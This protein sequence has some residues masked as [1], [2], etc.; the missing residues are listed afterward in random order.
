MS[1]PPPTVESWLS[2]EQ[3]RSL[4]NDVLDGLTKPF[5][6]LSPKHLYDARGSE[7][8]E[9]I[10][11]LP[12]YYPTRTEL[13]ILRDRAT[14]VV[15]DT[16]AAELVELGAGAADKARLLLDAM[17]EAGTLRRYVP[18]DVS[19]SVVA[20]AATTLADAY[21]GL[22]VH[23]VVGDFERHLEHVGRRDDAPRLVAL[24]GGTIGNFPPGTRRSILRKIAGL[25]APG[26]HLLLGTDLVKDPRV[27][28]AAYNDSQGVTA[29]FNRNL[30][31]VLNRE[32]DADFEPEAF[33]HVAFYDR[34][35][36]W[37]EMR[38]RAVRPCSVLIAG[39]DLRVEFAAGEELR[40]EISAKFTRPRVGADLAAAG[41]ALEQWHTDADGL[42]ALAVAGR[43][44]K[45]GR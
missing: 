23:G 27:I 44:S 26:D 8:F 5:K 1:S 15:A 7:L 45:D 17:H 35:H 19:E 6:E 43:A 36:E 40:T 16:A 34:R 25:L 9:L 18:L 41:L 14:A 22:G 30:L 21:P 3:S 11:G 24:L 42:F 20:V 32:L 29:A 39:L 13:A 10:C 2:D 31:H 12:E 4:A 33:D 28:E 38:L 37:I